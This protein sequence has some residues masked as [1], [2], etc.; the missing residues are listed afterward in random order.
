MRYNKSVLAA[1]CGTAFFAC[2][3][4]AAKLSILIDDFGY[5]QHEENQVLQ[6]PKAVSV[7]IFPNA[8]DSQM[9]MNKAHQQGR[10]ILIHLPMAPLSKQPLEKDTLTP[11]MSAAEVK[12]IVD[13]AISNIPYAIGINNHMGSAMTSSLTGMENVMQAMNA[14]NLFF[15]DSMTIGNTQ[16]VKAAQGTRVKVIKRNV[17]LDDV[18]NETEIRRQFERAIQLARKNGYAIAIGHPHPTTVKVLQQMLPNLP[19]DI[20]LVRPSDLLNEPQRSAATRKATIGPVKSSRKGIS[21]CRLRQPIPQIY[22]DSMFKV[23]GESLKSLPAL[24]FVERQYSVMTTFT[25]N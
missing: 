12:R 8:P 16:S 9:M 21:V 4:Q 3:V 11:S 15:L 10:E 2:Q 19:A 7:A 25:Q 20:V 18:Q 17:F 13:Q 22:A 24:E 1:V 23:L 5:R 6:M 14:H